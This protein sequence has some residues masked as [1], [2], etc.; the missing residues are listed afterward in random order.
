MQQFRL[1]AIDDHID[2]AELVARVARKCGYDA[3]AL[4]S[5]HDLAA[6]L[7]ARPIDVLS[8][9]LCMPDQDGIGLLSVL[10]ENNFKGAIVIVSGQESWLRK[11]VGRLAAARGL[12]IAG[13]FAKPLDLAAMTQLLTKL[14]SASAQPAEALAVKIG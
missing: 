9:D 1:L 14:Q 3:E 10:Q 11:S 4:A 6:Q 2:S 7:N 5:H 12:K 13:D 8:L